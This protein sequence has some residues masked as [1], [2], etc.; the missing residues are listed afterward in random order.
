MNDSETKVSKTTSPRDKRKRLEEMS[1]REDDSREEKRAR[2]DKDQRTAKGELKL[3][4]IEGTRTKLSKIE[5]EQQV[6][7]L[8]TTVAELRQTVLRLEAEKRA[9]APNGTEQKHV[10]DPL[11]EDPLSEYPLT[12]EWCPSDSHQSLNNNKTITKAQV[13]Y[14]SAH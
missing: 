12:E 14:P 13:N 6:K 4:I 5:L 1:E 8:Q 7:S 11:T 3:N 10:G 9:I 2:R